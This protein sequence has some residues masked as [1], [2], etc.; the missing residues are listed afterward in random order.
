MSKQVPQLLSESLRVFEGL[1]KHLCSTVLPCNS[2]QLSVNTD[3][4]ARLFVV[5]DKGRLL[6]SIPYN[7]DGDP[8]NPDDGEWSHGSANDRNEQ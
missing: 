5:D 7:R 1:A 8:G 6:V 3:G 4:T 2:I